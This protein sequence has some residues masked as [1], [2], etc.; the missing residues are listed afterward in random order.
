ML[1]IDPETVPVI[2]T[3]I[4]DRIA[5]PGPSCA[6]YPERHSER[7]TDA[8]DCTLVD[9]T[10]LGR[11]VTFRSVLNLWNIRENY[12]FYQS[13]STKLILSKSYRFTIKYGMELTRA[14]LV[15]AATRGQEQ[16]EPALHMRGNVGS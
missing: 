1:C 13:C 4:P 9:M 3:R 7:R 8:T 6:D 2:L 16:E 5:G 10:R 11:G 14:C 12:I 15:S